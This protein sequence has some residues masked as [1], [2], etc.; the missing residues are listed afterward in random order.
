MQKW[1]SQAGSSSCMRPGARFHTLQQ[2]LE[3]GQQQGNDYLVS[4]ADYT[5]PAQH[6]WRVLRLLGIGPQQ[7]G[8]YRSAP[9]VAFGPCCS[10]FVVM[11]WRPVCKGPRFVLLWMQLQE[12]R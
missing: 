6:D 11:A 10:G 9:A 7:D 8:V 4:L 5:P 2:G 3:G 12:R 1:E